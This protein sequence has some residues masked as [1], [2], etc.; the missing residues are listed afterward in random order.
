MKTAFIF[1]G[2][3]SQ[4]VGMGKD[5]G[6][7]ARFF[8]IANDVLGYDLK[9]ICFDGPEDVLRQTSNA[10]PAILACSMA[11]LYQKEEK[12]DMVA[13]HSLGE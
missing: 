9:S 5:L 1:P 13:G 3:G 6:E 7:T 10:Q 8:D 11:M 12:P 2:Q 4:I